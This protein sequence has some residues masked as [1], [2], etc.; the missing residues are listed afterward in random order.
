MLA[1]TQVEI[2]ALH[3]DRDNNN[4]KQFCSIPWQKRTSGMRRE[5]LRTIKRIIYP[6]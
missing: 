5:L 6:A 3:E 2:N 4:D 1:D